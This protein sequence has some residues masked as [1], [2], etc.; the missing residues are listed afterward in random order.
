VETAPPDY[1]PLP[2]RPHRAAIAEYVLSNRERVCAIA[3]RK[4]P[5]GTR[6]AID[7][8]EILSSVL[9]RL[10]LMVVRNTLRPHSESELWGLIETIIHNTTISKS[11]LIATA[12]KHLTEQGPYA[13]EFLKRLNTCRDDD[14][15]G[16]LVTRM[17]MSLKKAEDRQLFC[18]I[19]RGASHK[20]AGAF[21]GVSEPASRQRWMSVRRELEERFVGGHFDD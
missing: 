15:A 19:H 6:Q 14:E 1:W 8:E 21:L 2:H 9:R 3:R 4:I 13:Y 20:A 10:D 5:A 17:L 11:Q 16:V 18:L 7:S 12:R